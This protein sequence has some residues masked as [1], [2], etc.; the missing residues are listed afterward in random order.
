[1][2]VD[3]DALNM[4]AVAPRY[5]EHWIL[6][7]HSKEAARLMGQAEVD[8]D[9]FSVADQLHRR[10]GGV[11]VLKGLGSIVHGG[12]QQSLCPFGNPGMATAGMGDV[13]AGVIGGLIG[14]TPSLYQAAC[15]GVVSHARAA[16]QVAD[17]L[18]EVGLIAS[19]LPMAIGRCLSVREAS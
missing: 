11:V 9:R 15:I 6:T 18:G 3:A 1:M 10:F 16:E 5:F 7:P 17:E 4:L 2:V 12:E 19:D 8:D 14:Q 13:L